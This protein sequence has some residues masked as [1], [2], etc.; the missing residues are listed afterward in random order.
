[1]TVHLPPLEGRVRAALAIVLFGAVGLAS[2]LGAFIPLDHALRDWRFA[3]SSRAATGQVV[4]VDINSASL[5]AVG[6][7]PW[8]RH[9]H[10][11]M[12][13]RLMQLGA[14]DVVFDV[15]FSAA[16]TETEDSAFERSL[17]DA[18]GFAYLA[19]FRQ[20]DTGRNGEAA[21][22]VPLQRFTKN[23]APVAVNVSL[24]TGGVVR[25][26]PLAMSIGG[27]PRA[28]GRDCARRQDRRR[29]RGDRSRFLHQPRIGYP[30]FRRRSAGR[31][32][33]SAAGARSPGGDRRVRGG[34]ARL[35][36]RPPLRHCAR[37]AAADSRRRN[38]E[39]GA[40]PRALRGL[41]RPPDPRR[42]HRPR[43]APPAAHRRRPDRG[44]RVCN[45]RDR[46]VRRYL[47][48]RSIGPYSS[49]PPRWTPVLP[50]SR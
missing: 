17:A 9:L 19:A 28:L 44:R 10:A 50:L 33:R 41:A 26:Y 35:L 34:A 45:C 21:Y 49:T 15:D 2:V 46:R 32:R 37:R 20:H 48:F 30:H 29:Q 12:L 11:Q 1:M 6:V 3:L 47:C 40:G 31:T 5:N 18:G 16:S 39:T 4:F 8:P 7:W 13:D 23:A 38:P 22:N 24:D 43:L 27:Q 42:L 14:T 36:R 25:T